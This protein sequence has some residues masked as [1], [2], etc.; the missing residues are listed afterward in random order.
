MS[1]EVEHEK[2]EVINAESD[3]VFMTMSNRPNL[4]MKK[5]YTR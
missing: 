1:P 2:T 3:M 4:I 5:M